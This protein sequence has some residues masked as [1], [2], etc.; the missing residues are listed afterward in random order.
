MLLLLFLCGESRVL[1]WVLVRVQGVCWEGVDGV[2]YLPGVRVAV[3]QK[4]EK[5]RMKWTVMRVTVSAELSAG[6]RYVTLGESSCGTEAC[7][8]SGHP[9]TPNT[10]TYTHPILF[11]LQDSACLCG[12]WRHKLQKLPAETW[13]IAHR[14]VRRKKKRC[15]LL[16]WLLR[17]ISTRVLVMTKWHHCCT[18]INSQQSPLSSIKALTMRSVLM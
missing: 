9:P 15:L 5:T 11:S 17:Q 16:T 18:N 6:W 1:V 2:A 10:H 13:Q 14:L 7:G 12:S 4:S 3:W 8:M